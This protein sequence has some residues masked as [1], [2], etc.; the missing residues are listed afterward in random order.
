M[1]SCPYPNT[2]V[3]LVAQNSSKLEQAIQ[4]PHLRR[5]LLVDEQIKN[6]VPNWMD[7]SWQHEALFD[8][9]AT[10]VVYGGWYKLVRAQSEDC[11]GIV[12]SSTILRL[13]KF[14]HLLSSQSCI[15]K[16]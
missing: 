11:F 5:I 8:V 7:S 13:R 16:L 1:L 15:P 6:I 14:A 9:Q 4:Q 10:G 12:S 2:A 3:T